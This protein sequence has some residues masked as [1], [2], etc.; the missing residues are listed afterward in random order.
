MAG[1]L[2]RIGLGAEGEADAVIVHPGDVYRLATAPP[3]KHYRFQIVSY[4]NYYDPLW[5]QFYGWDGTDTFF[6]IPPAGKRLPFKPGQWVRLT[7]D[8]Q[9]SLG[10]KAENLEVQVLKDFDPKGMVSAAGRLDDYPSLNARLV[11]V[12]GVVDWQEQLDPNHTR[13]SLVVEGHALT[14]TI[15][16]TAPGQAPLLSGAVVRA[17]G[18]YLQRTDINKHLTGIE[19]KVQ[20]VENL[21]IVGWLDIDPRFDTPKSMMA[22]VAQMSA[23]AGVHVVGKVD[24]FSPGSRV[25][26]RD[27]SGLLEIR[28]PQV[29]GLHVGAE[30][31]AI[32]VRSADNVEVHLEQAVWRLRGAPNE[33]APVAK[34]ELNLAIQVLELPTE[35]AAARQPVKLTGVVTWGSNDTRFFF[36]QDRSGG[37]KVTVPPDVKFTGI[38]AGLSAVVTGVTVMGEYAPEVMLQQVVVGVSMSA[39]E[40]QK[41]SLEQARTGGSEALWVEMEGYVRSVE[42]IDSFT[43]MD[44]TTATGEFRAMLPSYE[45]AQDKI[46]AFVRI[47][48]VCDAVANENRR[49]TGVQL[50]VPLEEHINVDEAPIADPFSTPFTPLESLGRFGSEKSVSRRI[51]TGGT[52]TYQS[53][54]RFLVIQGGASSILVLNRGKTLLAAGDQADVVGIPGWNGNRF[55]LREGLLMKTSH[56]GE[57]RPFA[58][59]RGIVLSDG[60]DYRLVQIRGILT[61]VIDIGSEFLL[62]IR[63]GAD[64]V[65]ARIDH[66]RTPGIPD[67]WVKGSTVVANGIF[68]LRFDE[69]R[70][71]TGVDLLLRGNEDLT[72]VTPAPFWTVER[73]LA[74]AGLIGTGALCIVMWVVSLR[75]RVQRQTE[76]IRGQT[77]NQASLEAELE[78][79][80]RL[81]SLGLLAGGIAHDFNN[82]L[83]V[84]MGNI[85][86][87]L[88]DDVAVERVG[89]C[90]KDAEEGTKRAHSLTLQLLTFA[91]G[92]EPV[93]ISLLLPGVVTEAS[94]LALSGSKSRAEFSP[95]PD[96]WQVHADRGQLVR[97]IQSIVTHAGAEMPEGGVV[98]IGALNE[99]VSE[100]TAQPLKPGRYV[101]LSVADKGK[102]MPAEQLSGIFDPYAAAKLGKNQ[103]GLATAYSILKK[104]GG[105]IEVH[106]EIGRGTSMS[107]WIPAYSSP[108]PAVV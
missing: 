65:V 90:L 40:P 80:Q 68:R 49:S 84:I 105:I 47:R 36:I 2:A 58:L 52:V 70:V 69:N 6:M 37:V 53:P 101:R 97:A 39:P 104:H 87:A 21:K 4:V 43:R 27:D 10:F 20:G 24:S 30:I 54:G 74:V 33:A 75:H 1:P 76:Q 14:T 23:G 107:L 66:A 29:S 78:R 8:V 16:L 51:H 35:R 19:F 57:P 64:N 106:S 31:E 7:G 42:S 99:T 59:A 93:R 61:E 89:D 28:T 103:F 41:I 62:T 82:L 48:G 44:L 102:G 56:D 5:N 72:V 98:R 60:L 81:H 94:G 55:V 67:S 9:P 71:A 77:E 91:R 83:T 38:N 32:G 22:D 92:G 11:E 95:P 26:L 25:T 85:T 34:T 50:W 79:S 18:I 3:D 108:A 100:N 46:G 12:T 15:W 13:L 73:A 96:L 86:M 88:M 17:L 63:V 45:K